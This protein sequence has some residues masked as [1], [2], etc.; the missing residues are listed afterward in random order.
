MQKKKQRGEDKADK[1]K[2]NKEESKEKEGSSVLK[3][4]H[5]NSSGLLR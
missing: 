3:A 2:L 4:Q 5:K 1:K